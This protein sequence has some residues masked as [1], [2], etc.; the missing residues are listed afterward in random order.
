MSLSGLLLS[1]KFFSVLKEAYCFFS[2]LHDDLV[3]LVRDGQIGV[4]EQVLQ[5]QLVGHELTENG[6][7]SFR[8]GAFRRLL[9]LHRFYRTDCVFYRL[10]QRVVAILRWCPL[11][12]KNLQ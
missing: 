3:F 7:R 4:L 1:P 9:F 10:L 2:L 11:A 12:D 5:V 8:R 6:T